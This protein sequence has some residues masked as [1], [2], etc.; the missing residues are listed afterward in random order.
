MSDGSLKPVEQ[1]KQGDLVKG[2]TGENF[3]FGVDVYETDELIYSFNG[4]SF[5][6]TGEHPVKTTEGWK[7]IDPDLTRFEYRRVSDERLHHG[8]GKLGKLEV[9]DVIFGPNGKKITIRSIDSK[10][11]KGH[12]QKLYNPRLNGDHTY[13][14]DGI[15][16]HNP[17]GDEA[18]F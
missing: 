9:G 18:K 7:S 16:V 1:V 13:Y 10:V 2:E 8:L 11:N 5:F 3:V 14:A 17:A 15:L 6:I 12:P 4:G